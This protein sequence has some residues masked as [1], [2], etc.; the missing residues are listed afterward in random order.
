MTEEKKRN[1]ARFEELAARFNLPRTMEELEAACE[2]IEAKAAEAVQDTNPGQV[3]KA[4][5]D[6]LEHLRRLSQISPSVGGV[7][8]PDAGWQNAIR[9]SDSIADHVYDKY[10]DTPDPI[11]LTREENRRIVRRLVRIAPQAVTL[12]VERG[13]V[14]ATY[15]TDGSGTVLLR[16]RSPSNAAPPPGEE[17]LT[18]AESR[19]YAAITADEPRTQQEIADHTPSGS[20]DA[21]KKL[22]RPGGTLRKQGLVKFRKGAG[23]YRAK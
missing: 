20:I 4:A 17:R 6:M 1:A 2:R 14:E 11:P 21:V 22:L 18:E 23:Y 5:D 9:R 15:L 19:V 12:L 7:P 13:D 3:A 8:W 16:P 10:L